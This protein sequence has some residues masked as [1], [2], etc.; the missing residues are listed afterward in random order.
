MWQSTGME[1]ILQCIITAYPQ[2]DAYWE[3]NGH[4]LRT[5]HSNRHEVETYFSEANDG[6]IG[7]FSNQE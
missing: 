1:T 6:G 2:G 4:Y 7:N 5:A 3:F